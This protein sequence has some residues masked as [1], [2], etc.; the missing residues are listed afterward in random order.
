[1]SLALGA[2]ALAWATEGHGETEDGYCQRWVRQVIQDVYGDAYN[3]FM[4]ESAKKSAI[5]W[6]K[7]RADSTLPQGVSVLVTSDYKQTMI[8]DI[9]YKT[10]GSGDF[11]HVGI[12]VLGN[13][14]AE[15]SSTNYGRTHGA[16]GFRKLVRETGDPAS[17]WWGSPNVVV[18]LPQPQG[19]V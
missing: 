7:A 8:G 13:K 12:R 11:G 17:A 5:A 1:M 18:R 9:L 15:N 14:V 6:K 2:K 16:L 3:A 10:I 19:E 4:L